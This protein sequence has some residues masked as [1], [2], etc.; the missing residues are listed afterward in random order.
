MNYF[1][2]PLKISFCRK[3]HCYSY[4]KLKIQ[5][6]NFS[7]TT[8]TFFFFFFEKLASCFSSAVSQLA[9]SRKNLRAGKW[10][11]QTVPGWRTLENSVQPLQFTDEGTKVQDPITISLLAQEIIFLLYIPHT[12]YHVS[13]FSLQISQFYLCCSQY[14]WR[15]DALKEHRY[16]GTLIV[17][18]VKHK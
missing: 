3:I 13:S 5:T 1:V 12:Q 6:D 10:E 16:L 4:T 7:R 8:P 2:V 15:M 11:T 17:Y 9:I 14:C 18:R